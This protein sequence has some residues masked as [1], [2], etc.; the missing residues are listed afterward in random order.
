MAA[1]AWSQLEKSQ[2]CGTHRGAVQWRRRRSRCVTGDHWRSCASLLCSGSDRQDAGAVPHFERSADPA[3]RYLRRRNEKGVTP[4][5]R[6]RP[7]ALSSTAAA[8]L[9]AS[10]HRGW[11]R[12]RVYR[13]G[14][15]GP[16][17]LALGWLAR[18]GR[19]RSLVGQRAPGPAAPCRRR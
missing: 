18:R 12:S 15:S 5:H 11:G 19:P 17:P 6:R 10:G 16:A 1:K 8:G 7:R 2:S 3:A 9:A 4:L 14:R 13:R